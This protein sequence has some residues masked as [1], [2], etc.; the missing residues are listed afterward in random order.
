MASPVPECPGLSRNHVTGS[1]PRAPGCRWTYGV[2]S[3]ALPERGTAELCTDVRG[4]G[5]EGELCE[6]RQFGRPLG[7]GV[8]APAADT[9]MGAVDVMS[10][11]GDVRAAVPRALPGFAGQIPATSDSLILSAGS[12]LFSAGSMNAFCDVLLTTRAPFT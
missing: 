1:H 4:L 2:T 6:R 8:P 3:G 9:P 10:M 12:R 5:T 7:E 11:P